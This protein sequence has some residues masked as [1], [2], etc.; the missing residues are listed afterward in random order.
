[1]D[2]LDRLDENARLAQDEFGVVGL[3]DLHRLELHGGSFPVLM[4]KGG[5]FA[6][7]LKSETAPKT[8]AKGRER[9]NDSFHPINIVGLRGLKREQASQIPL[10]VDGHMKVDAGRQQ[11]GVACRCANLGQCTSPANAWLMNVCRPW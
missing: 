1:V 2:V 6:F 10:I 4:P 11:A 9:G 5:K 3:L 7:P 8:A